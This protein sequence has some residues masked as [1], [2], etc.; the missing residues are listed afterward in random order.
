MKV[1]LNSIKFMCQRYGCADNLIPTD[2]NE[3]VDKI[4]AQLGAVEE[5]IDIGKKYQGI[6]IAKVVECKDLEGSDHLHVCKI[7]DGGKA[8]GI[9][10]DDKGYVQVV[11]GAPNCRAGLTVAWLPPG[12]TVPESVDNGTSPRLRATR[13]PFVLE[14]REIRGAKS[15]GMLASPKELELGDNHDGILEIDENVAP[16]TDFAE[17]YELAGDVVVDIENKMFT[18]RPDCFGFLGVA[19][20]IAGI[21]QKPFKSPDWYT[22]TPDFPKVEVSELKL[23]VKNNLPKLVPRFTAITM[24]GIKVEPSP[25]W[26]QV[27]L[28]KAGLKPINNIVDL[29]NFFMLETGQP[30]HAYDYDKVK[31]LSGGE[32]KITIRYPESGEKIKLLNGKEIEPRKEAIM[33]ATDNQ[34]IGIGGVM[35]GSDTEVDAGTKNIILECANFDMYSIRRTSMEHGLFTDAVTRFTKGQSPRQNLAV[36]AKIVDEVRKN[37]GK[38]SSKLI[39]NK[40]LQP[41]LSAIH[42]TASFINERLGLEL[43]ASEMKKLLDNVEFKV[44]EDKSILAVAPPFWRTDIEIPEDVVEEVGRLYGYDHLPLELPRRSIAPAKKDELLEL[45]SRIRATLAKAGAG[46]VLTYSFVHGDLL[47]KVGQSPDNAFQIANALSPDLQYY[48]L[49]LTPSLLEK[50]HPNI[51]AGYDEFAIFELGKAHITGQNGEDG[52]PREDDLTSLVIAAADKLGKSGAPYYAARKYLENLVRAQLTYRPVPKEMQKFDITKPF[53]MNRAAF[54]YAGDKFLGIIGEFRT[55]VTRELKLPKFCA[56]FELDTVA[57][58]EII[59]QGS[60]TSLPRFPK[61]T[62]DIS[63]LVKT[64]VNFED[65]LSIVKEQLDKSK[66]K[67]SIATIEPLDIFQRGS[68]ATH[69]HISL[70]IS[71]ASHDRTLTADEINNLLNTIG[72]AAQNKIGAKRI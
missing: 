24:S 41:E 70:R 54:I 34:L 8:K 16:G 67:N 46:E 4:G 18:H 64:E 33:I 53:D 38:V 23:E 37:G 36:L 61:V 17:K 11:C 40:H 44:H 20:E 45:K 71:I 35:G 42:V 21:Q 29:T 5:V 31:A 19:R 1:S 25:V 13:E 15:N 43:K 48:R 51:K 60:Y 9:E 62:Q 12:T 14:A 22:P 63:M 56:G 30:L 58:L 27:E 68:A 59:G 32:A 66:P 52:L 65:L 47:Q 39:D 50:V 7:D 72:A 10:R 57:L 69:K 2:V 49:S 55:N 6:I 28:T 3:L 26:L